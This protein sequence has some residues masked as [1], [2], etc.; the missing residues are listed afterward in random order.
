MFNYLFIY[1]ELEKL[2]Y[3]VYESDILLQDTIFQSSGNDLTT[4]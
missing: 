1:V 4:A 3:N 2:N